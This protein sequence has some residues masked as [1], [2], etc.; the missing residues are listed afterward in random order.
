MR[1]SFVP[2]R[3]VAPDARRRRRKTTPLQVRDFSDLTAASMKRL[4]FD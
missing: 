4:P 2:A 3:I 1:N